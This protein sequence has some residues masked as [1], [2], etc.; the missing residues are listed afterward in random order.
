ME[1]IIC[2]LNITFPSFRDGVYI[3][4][5]MYIKYTSIHSKCIYPKRTLFL[6]LS[7]SFLFQKSFHARF[8]QRWAHAFF[9]VALL[10]FAL[11]SQALLAIALFQAKIKGL[12]DNA[13]FI[14]A[15]AE[16][17]CPPPP[18]ISSKHLLPTDQRSNHVWK[19]IFLPAF[20]PLTSPYPWMVG[21]RAIFLSRRLQFC[22]FFML[23]RFCVTAFLFCLLVFGAKA[24]K[25]CEC[26]HLPVF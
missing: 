14:C 22:Y 11:F 2:L 25:K 17:S 18:L 10:L 26:P 21:M 7:N 15:I 3:D 5:Y 16:F 20:D 23:L 9:L 6:S 19:L 24:R 8:S 13:L 1:I 4:S 12:L